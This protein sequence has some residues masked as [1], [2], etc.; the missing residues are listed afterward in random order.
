MIG[1]AV[2]RIMLLTLSIGM[3]V[4]VVAES[5][6]ALQEKSLD[7]DD[8]E[9][10]FDATCASGRKTA[11]GLSESFEAHGFVTDWQDDT[12][13]YFFRDGFTVN[14]HIYPGS[15]KCFVSAQN[16]AAPDLCQEL[17]SKGIELIARLPDGTCVAQQPE[18]G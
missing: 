11:A 1:Q 3:T 17:S 13:G 4:P 18:L 9:T 14:Y 6:D 8:I 15:W 12:Y 2:S 10:V 5:Q 16:A 7:Q